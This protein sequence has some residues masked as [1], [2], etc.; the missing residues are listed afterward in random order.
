E[1]V[2]LFKGDSRV[3]VARSLPWRESL[4]REENVGFNLVRCYLCPSFIEGD[5]TKDVGLRVANSHTSNHRG[6][7]FTPLETIRRFLKLGV[8]PF[9]ARRGGLRAGGKGTSSSLRVEC[10]VYIN[11]CIAFDFKINTRAYPHLTLNP[12][13]SRFVII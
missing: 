8:D 6:D 7:D 13:V 1:G 3:S 10:G 5:T 11:G 12:L 2:S 4:G 9:R